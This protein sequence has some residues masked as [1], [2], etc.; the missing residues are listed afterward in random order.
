MVFI[1][2]TVYFSI[3]ECISATVCNYAVCMICN[4]NRSCLPKH[5]SETDLC[6]GDK[7]YFQE[8][9]NWRY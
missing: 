4:I 9:W 3:K 5:H 8:V 2:C 7:I 1:I 6:N